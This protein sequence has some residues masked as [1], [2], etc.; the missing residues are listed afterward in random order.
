AL[1]HMLGQ[2]GQDSSGVV[3]TGQVG[4]IETGA[5]LERVLSVLP[6]AS[7]SW[8]GVTFDAS[9]LKVGFDS[10]SSIFTLSGPSSLTIPKLGTINVQLG[11]ASTQG[12]VITDDNFTSL[13][14]TISGNL[15]I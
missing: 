5:I 9:G 12:L 15:N 2:F 6:S 1:A 7:F 14:A 8:H 13:D 3:T 11:G 4:A 10:G